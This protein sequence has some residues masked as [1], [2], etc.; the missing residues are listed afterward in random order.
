MKIRLTIV[1]SRCRSGHHKAGDS[2][3]VED[4]C[5]PIC[6]E[7]WNAVYPYAFAL[8]NGASLDQGEAKARSCTVKC[9]DE[10]RVV[11][12]AEVVPEGSE[13]E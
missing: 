10:A 11:M 1:E 2:F 4:L 8:L 9:P 6:H 13:A 12:R 3:I 5:P 7:L